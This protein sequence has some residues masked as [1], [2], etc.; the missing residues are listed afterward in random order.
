MALIFMDVQIPQIWKNLEK[1]KN[2]PYASSVMHPSEPIR[3][4]CL[5]ISKSYLWTNLLNILALNSC[6]VSTSKDCPLFQ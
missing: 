1:S 5:K 2:K 3:H 6:T 4:L